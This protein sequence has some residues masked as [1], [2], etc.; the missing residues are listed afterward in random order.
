MNR[1]TIAQF[2]FN[3]GAIGSLFHS[4]MLE[5]ARFSSEIDVYADGVHI[6]I[7]NPY[8]MPFIRMRSSRVEDYEEVSLQISLSDSPG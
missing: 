4:A 3:N 7:G 2:R 1:A 6:V 5:G 8:H